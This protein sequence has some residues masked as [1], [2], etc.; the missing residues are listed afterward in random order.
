[1]LGKV[2]GALEAEKPELVTAA[3]ATSSFPVAAS[4]A[5]TVRFPRAR[6]PRLLLTWESSQC[7]WEDSWLPASGGQ[8]GAGPRGLLPLRLG[9]CAWDTRV[10]TASRQ[11]M[12]TAWA[13][14][15]VWGGL[16]FNM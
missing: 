4:A 10:G 14:W 13:G 9:G 11:G 7:P 15:G 12:C 2:E 5:Q 3:W 16:G 1:M 6:L 8:G